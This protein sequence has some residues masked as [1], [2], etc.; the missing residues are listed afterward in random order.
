MQNTGTSSDIEEEIYHTDKYN[1][2]RLVLDQ[3]KVTSCTKIQVLQ[4]T[5][6]P[7]SYY[8][9]VRFLDNIEADSERIPG[10][11]Y[12]D[13]TLFRVLFYQ[14]IKY[15]FCKSKAKY[16]SIVY[17]LVIY[18]TACFNI[19]GPTVYGD[20]PIDR[21]V[22]EAPENSNTNNIPRDI[23]DPRYFLHNPSLDDWYVR[24]KQEPDYIIDTYTQL[25]P[26]ELPTGVRRG[27]WHD[28]ITTF[29]QHQQITTETN[30][31]SKI[32]STEDHTVGLEHK[33]LINEAVKSRKRRK[34]APTWY[35]RESFN[36]ALNPYLRTEISH[37]L[38][39]YWVHTDKNN[40]FMNL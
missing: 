28:R 27:T 19:L 34:T 17:T 21:H 15:E 18:P 12:H 30:R 32:C 38:S 33:A 16:P 6:Y 10:S 39:G 5:E 26:L 13:R 11:I 1:Y 3:D 7:E 40:C 9:V 29:Y 25:R 36:P 8:Q 24:Q 37:L 31:Y 14:E 4:G 23:D 35:I 22:Q 20:F 2:V